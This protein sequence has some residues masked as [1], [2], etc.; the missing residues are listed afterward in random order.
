MFQIVR[1]FVFSDVCCVGADNAKRYD[2]LFAK[3]DTNKD[4][5]VDIHELRQGLKEMGMGLGEG[6]ALKIVSAGDSDD[7]GE[8]DI[9]EFSEYLRDHEKKLML[10][11]KSLDKNNDGRIDASEIRESL[12]KLGVKLSEE[13]AQKILSSIDADGTMTVDWNEWRAHFLLNPATNIEEIIRFWKKSSQSHAMNSVWR[14]SLGALPQYSHSPPW[15][16][17]YQ[18]CSTQTSHE[19]YQ[20]TANWL[21]SHTKHQPKV[22]I[23]CGSG[24][25][26]LADTLKCQ[27]SFDYSDIPSFPQSTVQGH[28]GRL[29]FGELKGK[30]CVC[31]Q[32]RFHMYEG[33]PLCKVTF[34]VRVFK[35]LG[36]ETLIVTNAAGSLSDSYKTG[37]IMIIKD[38]INLL[39]FA[40]QHP[41]NGPNDEQ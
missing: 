34:P 12:S 22:A 26:L 32:G 28:A 14:S 27:E 20:Q 36:V 31:M 19:E 38:H 39:G 1:K 25:G 6:A 8:L 23:I 33:Y 15:C 24:L 35:L 17:H 21:L 40:G 7:D 3:L 10:T 5:K 11:F 18:G 16:S 13:H 9:S 37:D 41:L 30:T 4:G 2:D 29:V